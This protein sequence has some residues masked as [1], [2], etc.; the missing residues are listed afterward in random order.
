MLIRQQKRRSW[1]IK[2]SDGEKE[3]NLNNK[4]MYSELVYFFKATLLKNQHQKS[5]D[6]KP[7]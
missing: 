4:Q 7:T 3:Q 1:R 5:A 2:N 6:D